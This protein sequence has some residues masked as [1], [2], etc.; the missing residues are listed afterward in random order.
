MKR[1]YKLKPSLQRE[2]AEERIK[3][4]FEQAFLRFNEDKNLSTRYVELARNISQ[5][6]KVKIPLP[7]KRQF[8]K[9]CYNYLMPGKNC[10]IRLTGKTITYSCKECK[11]FTRMPYH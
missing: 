7:Y 2:I 3:E 1:R 11:R 9:N 8:C 6:Y 4:L 5:K 10:T